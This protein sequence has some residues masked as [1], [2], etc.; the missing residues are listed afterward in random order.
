MPPE[1]TAGTT[2]TRIYPADLEALK[3]FRMRAS[4][5]PGSKGWLTLPEALTL[6]IKIATK[7]LG[8]GTS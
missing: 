4:L 5:K 2:T 1:I 6:A 3:Q 7:S 8:E